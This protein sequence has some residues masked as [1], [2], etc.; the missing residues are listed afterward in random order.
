MARMI[1][2]ITFRPGPLAGPLAAYCERHGTTP[3]EAVRLAVAKM[4]RV[5]APAMEGHVETIRRVNAAKRP[6]KRRK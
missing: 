4:L 2:R 1:D 5:E 3:S 6:R